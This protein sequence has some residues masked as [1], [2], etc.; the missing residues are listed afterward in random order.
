MPTL[1]LFQCNQK[2]NQMLTI[3]FFHYSELWL[4]KGSD[5]SHSAHFG[6][7][8]DCCMN[9]KNVGVGVFQPLWSPAERRWEALAEL[10]K[11]TESHRRGVCLGSV[12]TLR[13]RRAGKVNLKSAVM[14]RSFVVVFFLVRIVQL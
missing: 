5:S 4:A 1:E 8:L 2:G 14:F 11:V 6:E 10:H 12:D 9:W 13:K 7:L 3:M